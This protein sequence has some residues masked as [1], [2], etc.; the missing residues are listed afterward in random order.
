VVAAP[1]FQG[2]QVVS[3]VRDDETFL[4]TF[5]LG[6]ISGTGGILLIDPTIVQI[7]GNGASCADATAAG[8][9]AALAPGRR[10]RGGVAD[11]C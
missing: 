2:E 7:V 8:G 1:P 5:P 3:Q 10:L 6:R 11:L 9:P 4:A